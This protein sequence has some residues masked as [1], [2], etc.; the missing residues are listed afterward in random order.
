[1]LPGSVA[2]TGRCHR[3]HF[4]TQRFVGKSAFE[5]VP[6]ICGDDAT[7]A[8]HSRHF[9]DAFGRVRNEENH[10]RHDGCIE[11]VIRKRK[12]HRIAGGKLCKHSLLAAFERKRA[13][14]PTDLRRKRPLAR[15]DQ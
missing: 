15:S 10:K 4:V 9:S 5:H 13:E 3:T 2:A 12:H 7:R 1:M 6:R 8:D 11:T 14:L